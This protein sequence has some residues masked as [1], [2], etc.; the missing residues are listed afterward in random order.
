LILEKEKNLFDN[1][2]NRNLAKMKR[3]AR[4]KYVWDVL[5]W[6]KTPSQCNEEIPQRKKKSKRTDIKE[7]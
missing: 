7:D 4:K 2:Y 1:F 3:K 5:F 6:G